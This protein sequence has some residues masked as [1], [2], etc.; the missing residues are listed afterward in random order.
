MSN[1]V[2]QGSV[3][4]PILFVFARMIC[5]KRCVILMF[6]VTRAN[7]LLLRSVSIVLPLLRPSDM[8]L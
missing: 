4:S 2:R 7:I 6:V 8:Y 5:L 1:C 3:L